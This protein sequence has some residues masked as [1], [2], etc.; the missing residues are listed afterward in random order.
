MQGL[1]NL[2]VVYVER[3]DLLRAEKCF[4]RAS[5]LAPHE[6]YIVRHLKIVQTRITKLTSSLGSQT[7]SRKSVMQSSSSVFEEEEEFP[8]AREDCGGGCEGTTQPQEQGNN[9]DFEY[10]GDNGS[11]KNYLPN[12]DKVFA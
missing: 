4:I 10:T 3:G 12:T 2:C 7:S 9:G 5:Q 11:N 8:G 1:H 6:E